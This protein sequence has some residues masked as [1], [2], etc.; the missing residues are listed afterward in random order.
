MIVSRNVTTRDENDKQQP[1]NLSV[2][3][4]VSSVV[5]QNDTVY[6]VPFFQIFQGDL[7]R[8][9]VNKPG[10]AVKPVPL[11]TNQSYAQPVSNVPDN[12]Y[13]NSY[14][15]IASDGSMA[16][17]VPAQKALTWQLTDA[18]GFGI[19]KER[20]WVTLQPGEIRVCTSC[21]GLNEMDQL[22]RSQPENPPLALL[23]LLEY[24][25]SNDLIFQN[26]FE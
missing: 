3:G 24:W 16:A 10:R 14:F 15:K 26:G 2:P 19:V 6:Q 7:V 5:N 17:M 8:D 11:H 22:D 18:D 21:H 12:Q 25:K 4:G 13:S 1:Y 23:E 20:V 9:H